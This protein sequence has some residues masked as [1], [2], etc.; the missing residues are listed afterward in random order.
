MD[1]VRSIY[2]VI[3]VFLQAIRYHELR[4]HQERHQLTDL[5]ILKVLGDIRLSIL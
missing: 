4:M 1:V 2:R 3:P 5:S